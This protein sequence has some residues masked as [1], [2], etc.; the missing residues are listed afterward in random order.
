MPRASLVL[1]LLLPAGCHVVP[2]E[3]FAV[4]VGINAASIAIFGRAVGDLAVSALSGRD[5]SIVRLDRRE[6]YCRA[7]EPPPSPPPFCTRGLGGVDCWA[8]PEALHM[9]R[10]IADGPVVLTPEQEANR[11]RRWP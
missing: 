3:P 4:L 6:S 11:T 9:V 7:I 8:N 1:F 5:C 10:Q 2:P